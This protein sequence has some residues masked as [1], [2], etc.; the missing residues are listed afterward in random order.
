VI[1]DPKPIECLARR[2]GETFY[3]FWI[4]DHVSYKRLLQR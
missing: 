3:W 1:A 4:G 2:R